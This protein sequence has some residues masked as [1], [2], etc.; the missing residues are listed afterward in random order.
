[1][2]PLIKLVA[3]SRLAE[4]E[5]APA[6]RAREIGLVAAMI[7][8]M[9]GVIAGILAARN[10]A[11]PSPARDA[12]PSEATGTSSPASSSSKRAA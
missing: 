7:P 2:H 9:A 4:D 10:E 11:A 3:I 12:K 1:M 5:G 8:G 6:G